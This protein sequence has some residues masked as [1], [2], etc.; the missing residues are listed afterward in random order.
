MIC[1]WEEFKADTGKLYMKCLDDFTLENSEMVKII[2]YAGVS[3][4]TPYI[5]RTLLKV[6]SYI[7]CT[8]VLSHMFYCN[9]LG[10]NVCNLCRRLICKSPVLV[11]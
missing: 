10:D 7:G 6:L 2:N 11:D 5:R 8:N 3:P 9:R 1:D 4:F